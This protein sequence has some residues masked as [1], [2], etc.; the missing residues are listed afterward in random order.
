MIDSKIYLNFMRIRQYYKNLIIFLPLIFAPTYFEFE[1]IILIT[2]GFL[3]LCLVSS[4]NYVRNDIVDIEVDKSHPKKKNRPLPSGL[5]TIKQAYGFYIILIASGISLAFLL[6]VY[7]GI[8]AVLLFL[9][10]EAYSRWLKKMV[11][12][13]VFTIGGNFI[14]RA[15]A[16]IILIQSSLSPWIIMGVFFVA[17]FLGFMK[18]KGELETLGEEAHKH[19]ITLQ[20]YTVSS[21]NSMVMVSAMLIIT[22]YSFYSLEGPHG[23]WRLVLTVPIMTFVI[24]RQLHL[25]AIKSPI[26]QS[27]EVLKDKATIISMLV[28][29]IVTM[30]LI[31]QVPSEFFA[32][33]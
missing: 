14:I 15:V 9:I 8:M 16:G 19:R 17:L 10:T 28:Y 3:S 25:S 23:D 31:Y 4:A 22:T 32:H 1:N 11:I 30:Y 2:L 29:V 33:I 18:R 5:I 7:F 26:A 13:D 21:I 27:N 24:L 6:S 20:E 12:L